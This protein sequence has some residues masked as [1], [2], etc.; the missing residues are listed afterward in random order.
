MSVNP[1]ELK[2]GSIQEGGMGHLPL[3]PRVF[4]AWKPVLITTATVT[5]SELEGYREW[6]KAGGGEWDR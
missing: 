5:E 6:E 4:S 2:V 1:G 3:S